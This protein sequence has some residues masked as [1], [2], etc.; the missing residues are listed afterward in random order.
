MAAK[1]VYVVQAFEVHKKKLVPTTKTEARDE[2]SARLRAAQA[3]DRRDGA[4][5]IALSLETETGEVSEAKILA[6]FGSV[7]DDLDQLIESF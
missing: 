6:C 5:V 3:A 1:T 2:N 7:T 4:A